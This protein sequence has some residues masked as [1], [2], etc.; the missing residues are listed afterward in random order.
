LFRVFQV[1]VRR[2]AGQKI[3]EDAVVWIGGGYGP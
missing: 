1:M 2:I 3:E